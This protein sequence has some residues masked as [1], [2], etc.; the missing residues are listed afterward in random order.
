MTNQKGI[1]ENQ[2]KNNAVGMPYKD[3]E[4]R[5]IKGAENQRRYRR[6]PDF[7][8]KLKKRRKEIRDSNIYGYREKYREYYAANKE[9]ILKRTNEY[10]KRNPQ[11]TAKAIEKSKRLGK[12]IAKGIKE[13]EELYDGYVYA[14]LRKEYGVDNDFLNKNKIFVELKKIILKIKRYESKSKNAA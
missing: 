11:V 1:W 7:V 9:A 2:L 10:R 8:L 13:R 14:L 12:G 6:N 5:R 3:A 4:T